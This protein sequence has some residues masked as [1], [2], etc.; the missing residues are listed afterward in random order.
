MS[1]KDLC[2]I[3]F[4]D[5]VVESGI[6]VLKI[7]GRGR[8]PEYVLTTV[9]C[10]REA[11]DAI[12]D[13]SYGPEKVKGWMDELDKVYNRGFWSGYY[14]G[15][16]MGEWHDQN[17]SKATQ[18]KVYIAKGAHYYPKTKIA[19]FLVEA[20]K[21]EQGDKV[22][23]TGPTTGIV[24]AQLDNFFVNG[25][26]AEVAVKG[27]SLTFALAERIRTTDKLYK[28]IPNPDVK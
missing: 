18:K 28:I 5:Q 11:I 4:L 26:P 16:K 19:E 27:D 15:Q 10:Y 14:L 12:A 25:K 1:P 2:T 22:L 6:K 7:E 21:V 13:G 24:E 9:R 3:N 17:G 8:A 20:Q 23:I